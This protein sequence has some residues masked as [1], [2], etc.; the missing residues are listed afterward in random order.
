MLP[1][2]SIFGGE[3]GFGFWILGADLKAHR[4]PGEEHDGVPDDSAYRPARGAGGVQGGGGV[5]LE[6]APSRAASLWPSFSLPDRNCKLPWH[7]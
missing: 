5:A 7:F 2:P 3:A 6:G 1:Q 4:T